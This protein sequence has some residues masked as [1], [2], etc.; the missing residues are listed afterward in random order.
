[1]L[2]LLNPF[3]IAEDTST[4]TMV[5]LTDFLR[6]V[7]GYWLVAGNGYSTRRPST[8]VSLRIC[9]LGGPCVMYYWK[10]RQ[11]SMGTTPIDDC[12]NTLEQWLKGAET[13]LH[14]NYW[15]NFDWLIF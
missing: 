10:Y 9:W 1:M 3:G 11:K 6:K 14:S 8:D 7:M 15:P 13:M 5:E 4:Y 12:S 2:L